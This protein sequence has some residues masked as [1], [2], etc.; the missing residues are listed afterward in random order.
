MPD[1]GS[2]KV[3]PVERVDRDEKSVGKQTE[4]TDRCGE[5]EGDG[6]GLRHR[7]HHQKH[8][9]Q[10]EKSSATHP[11]CTRS[12][13]RERGRCKNV[14]ALTSPHLRPG[15]PRDHRRNH[16]LHA[17]VVVKEVVANH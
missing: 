6:W 14:C 11:E 5:M 4:N 15:I 1:P 9:I 7:R 12:N 13:R 17:L 2:S 8:T 3:T 16:D 10:L